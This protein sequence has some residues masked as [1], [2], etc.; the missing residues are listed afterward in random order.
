MIA[1]LGPRAL[2]LSRGA[3]DRDDD[4]M[5]SGPVYEASYGHAYLFSPPT[6]GL[7]GRNGS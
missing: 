1:E 4:Y 6:A 5:P 7:G 2:G 3:S